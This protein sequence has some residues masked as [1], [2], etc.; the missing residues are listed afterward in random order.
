MCGGGRTIHLAV[1][2]REDVEV[3][4]AEATPFP[5]IFGGFS[6]QWLRFRL[7]VC[8]WDCGALAW[9]IMGGPAGPWLGCLWVG[10]RGVGLDPLNDLDRPARVASLGVGVVCGI[11]GGPVGQ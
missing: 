11:W 5:S 8:G 4:R 6:F 9:L 1:D 2:S 10:L 3:V 7:A